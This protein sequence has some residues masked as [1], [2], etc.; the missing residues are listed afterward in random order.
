M[1]SV[2]APGWPSQALPVLTVPG[3][4][5]GLRDEPRSSGLPQVPGL[6]TK[7]TMPKS[8]VV[9]TEPCLRMPRPALPPLEPLA[10]LSMLRQRV[11]S[12]L[13]LP[14][15]TRMPGRTPPLGLPT[16]LFWM[17]KLPVLLELVTPAR[18]PLPSMPVVLLPSISAVIEP[19]W[20]TPS[21]LPTAMPDEEAMLA[22]A[23]MTLLLTVHSITAR[24][25]PEQL[26]PM[27]RKLR[28]GVPTVPLALMKNLALP[29]PVI[30][31]WMALEPRA[32]TLAVAPEPA[33][34]LLAMVI[35]LVPEVGSPRPAGGPSRALPPCT[36]MP[37]PAGKLVTLLLETVAV[38]M[39]E[40][41]PAEP[42]ACTR[43]PLPWQW[44]VP[45]VLPVSLVSALPVTVR[46]LMVPLSL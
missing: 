42:L 32:S 34:A 26:T 19:V 38:V 30:A 15:S 3:L 36:M 20:P 24:L 28:T 35:M 12:P 29:V 25:P 8:L 27:P 2:F 14:D 7:P 22:V 16:V 39:T 1:A 9:A 11:V 17:V 40:A 37:T 43:I 44:T 33:M 4:V 23:S 21:W 41:P 6:G 10:L 46:L 31:V 13:A 18:M 5:P 45:A